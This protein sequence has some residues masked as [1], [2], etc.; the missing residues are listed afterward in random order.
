[1]AGRQSARE[2]IRL[3]P[4]NEIRE[5][6][7]R[8]ADVRR[9]AECSWSVI[10]LLDQAP[11]REVTHQ[12][13]VSGIIAIADQSAVFRPSQSSSACW[14]VLL[15]DQSRPPCFLTT[16]ETALP[17]SF[18]EAS[19]PWNSGSSRGYQTRR[20]TEAGRGC[21]PLKKS[22]SRSGYFVCEMPAWLIAPIWGNEG[23][24]SDAM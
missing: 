15:K 1:M 20:K 4:L 21:D 12:H 13:F 18:I 5:L 10:G 8:D 3:R 7:D 17:T 19:L 23:G 22:E 6:G 2:K 9:P 11:E 14:S 24:G 16:A